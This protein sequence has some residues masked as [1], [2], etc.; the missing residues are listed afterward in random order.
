MIRLG[1]VLLGKEPKIALTI[2]EIKANLLKPSLLKKVDILEVRIDCFKNI[3]EENVIRFISAIKKTC[4]TALRKALPIIATIRS[5]KEGGVRYISSLSRLQLFRTI[6]PLADAVDVELSSS[7]LDEVAGEAKEKKKRVIL[8]YHNF[9]QTPSEQRLKEIIKTA[10]K[11]GGEIIKIACFAKSKKDT[12]R[13]LNLLFKHREKNIVA[14]SLGEEGV[15]S[16]FLFPFFGSLWT[17]ACL[18]KPFAPGQVNINKLQ[19]IR[20]LC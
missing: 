5:K 8:S 12:L 6:I 15:I 18:D 2:G 11:R 16:R 9:K 13:L 4:L 7:I 10:E 20:R 14:I 19:I 17:Y 1:N 3:E